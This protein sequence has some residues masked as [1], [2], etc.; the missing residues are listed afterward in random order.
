[1]LKPDKRERASGHSNLPSGNLSSFQQLT[2]PLKRALFLR[3]KK[4]GWPHRRFCHNRG[5]GSLQVIERASSM[6]YATRFTHRKLFLTRREWSLCILEAG[7]THGTP[8]QATSLPSGG[9]GASFARNF[10]TESSRLIS[11][12]L[13]STIFCSIVISREPSKRRSAIGALR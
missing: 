9:A 3:E 5:L 11:A 4:N 7:N 8:T 6:Q 10:S 1:S 12:T 13:S 2:L